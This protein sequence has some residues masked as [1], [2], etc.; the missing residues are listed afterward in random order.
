MGAPASGRMGELGAPANG[1][2]GES[3][4]ACLACEAVASKGDGGAGWSSD[5][6]LLCEQLGRA[7]ERRLKLARPDSPPP[8]SP[9]PRP[10]AVSPFRPLAGGNS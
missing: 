1:R 7:I 3:R 10:I 5:C 6:A 4:G 8:R 2:A 9:G